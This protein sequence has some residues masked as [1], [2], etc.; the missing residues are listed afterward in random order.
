MS[1]N[2]LAE[3]ELLKKIAS[4]QKLNFAVFSSSSPNVKFIWIKGVTYQIDEVMSSDKTSSV[5]RSCFDQL[6]KIIP[7]IYTGNPI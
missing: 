7:P 2:Y 6:L 1:K 4:E 5:V 3:I